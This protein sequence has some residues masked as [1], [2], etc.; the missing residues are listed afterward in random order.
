M[1]MSALWKPA[2]AKKRCQFWKTL[3]LAKKAKENHVFKPKSS[4]QTDCPTTDTTTNTAM[5]TC[6]GL[7]GSS[8]RPTWMVVSVLTE[9]RECLRKT[10]VPC[11]MYN[12][13]SM[14]VS[15]PYNIAMKKLRE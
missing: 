14:M 5:N 15:R 7:N 2:V 12:K 3:R 1:L 8:H 6:G 10:A 13:H 9:L 11:V 4:T